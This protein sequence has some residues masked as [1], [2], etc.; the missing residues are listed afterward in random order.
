MTRTV[1]SMRSVAK[2]S[3]ESGRTGAGVVSDMS[4]CFLFVEAVGSLAG[5]E[6]VRVFQLLHDFRSGFRRSDASIHQAFAHELGAL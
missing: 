5:F 4:S 1:M 6:E 2:S 3:I